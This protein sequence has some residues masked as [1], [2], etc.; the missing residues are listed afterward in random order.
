MFTNNEQDDEDECI[1][2]HPNTVLHII[3]LSIF[4]IYCTKEKRTF[5]RRNFL[6]ENKGYVHKL[7]TKTSLY[8]NPNLNPTQC[9]TTSSTG[10]YG[11]QSV[12]TCKSTLRGR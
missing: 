8:I 6:K 11:H 9:T 10:I 2:Y 7:I 5:H 4:P 3:T 12:R 1:R